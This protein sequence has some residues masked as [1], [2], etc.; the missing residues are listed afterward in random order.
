M[1]LERTAPRT[2]ATG[3]EL[4]SPDYLTARA[5]F[6]A[7]AL[8]AGATLDALPLTAQGPCAEALSIDIAWLGARQPRRVV[9]HI[10]GVHGVEAFAG[11]AAQLALLAEPPPLPT[12]GALILVHVLN[13]Y[14]MAWLRR[15]NEHNVDLN[16]NFHPDG[17]TWAGT[18]P[19]YKRLD[20]LLNPS[21]PPTRDGFAL[22]LGFAG[23]RHGVRAVRQAIAHGQHRYP[24][25]LFYGGAELQPGPRLFNHW[26]QS[27]L[28]AAKTVFAIDMHTGLGPHAADTLIVEREVDHASLSAL[29]QALQR[30]LTG[31][32]ETAPAAYTVRG[33]LGAALPSLLPG[34]QVEFVLQEIGTWSPLRVLRELREE[35]RWHHYGAGHLDHPAKRRLLE[36]LCPASP[37]WRKAAVARHRFGLSCC[38]MDIQEQPVVSCALCGTPEGRV[39]WQDARCCVVQVEEPGYPGFCRVIWKTHV[40]EMSDLDEA[41]RAHCMRIVFAVERVLYRAMQP[42]KINLASLG[43]MVPHVHWHVIPRFADDPHFPQPIW[44]ERQRPGKATRTGTDPAALAIA[45]AEELKTKLK[46]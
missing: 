42:D 30:P 39:L 19:L 28:S 9:L 29:S 24:H 40:R 27:R 18:P 37:A 4:F 44:G 45:I 13:P 22:R 32:N 23:L 1:P 10:T 36:A 26:L 21:S 14:G 7:V 43:N 12:D 31:G 3:A 11:S 41:D 33:S 6:R 20:A 17:G 15:A 38:R 8:R 34:V 25:G 46:Q 5:R 2:S 35:N 16:R